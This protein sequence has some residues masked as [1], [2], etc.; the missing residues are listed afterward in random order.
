MKCLSIDNEWCSPVDNEFSP[1]DNEV[2]QS[3]VDELFSPVDNE[4]LTCR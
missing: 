2:L 1:V 3:C 4:V